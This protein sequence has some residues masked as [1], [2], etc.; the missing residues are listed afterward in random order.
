M[1]K[2]G[3]NKFLLF[4]DANDYDLDICPRPKIKSSSQ[5][6][7]TLL[8]GGVSSSSDTP[9]PPYGAH[10]INDCR[11]TG[12]SA[13]VGIGCDRIVLPLPNTI[14]RAVT[15]DLQIDEYGPLEALT[16]YG[17]AYWDQ[18]DKLMTIV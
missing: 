17:S 18:H 4:V 10:N 2:K 15:G 8:E 3:F 9:V 6:S 12:F 7:H 14:L 5:V 13:N 11:N 16:T 1:K